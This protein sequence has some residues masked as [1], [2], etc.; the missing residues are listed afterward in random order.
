MSSALQYLHSHQVIYRDLKSDN[1]LVWSLPPPHSFDRSHPVD[2]KL[3]DYGVSRLVQPFGMKGF[4]GT[5]AFMAPEI[6]R[7]GGEET[8]TEKVRVSC[9][10]V[11][12]CLCYLLHKGIKCGC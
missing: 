2:V 1:I 3:A 7:H 4:A 9:F 10:L 12:I 11:F 8:Y 6:I 5:L